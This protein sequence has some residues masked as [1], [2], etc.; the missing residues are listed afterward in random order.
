MKRYEEYKASGLDWLG[1]VPA[2][3]EIKKAKY[4]YKEMQSRSLDGSEDLLSVSQYTGVTRSTLVESERGYSLE[5]YRKVAS[6]D[7]VIN[8]MLAWMGALG[9]SNYVGIVS[10][11]YCVYR[12]HA[13][14]NPKFFGYLFQTPRYLAEFARCSHGIV[15]SR[16]RMYTEDFFN[17]T[18]LLPTRE[19]QNAIVAFLDRKLAEIDRFIANKERFIALLKEQKTAIINKAVTRGIDPDV[20]MKPSGI[21]WL[22]EIP[23]SWEE[24]RLKWY[25]A[26]V[27][28]GSRGW[29]DYYSDNGVIFLRIG[30]LSSE[31]IELKLDSIQR[32]DL[33]NKVEGIRTRVKQNDVLVSITASIGSIGLVASNLE[34]AYV[35]Q[36]IALLRLKDG[37]I[38]SKW[39]AYCLHSVV[40]KRQFNT[41][42]YGGTK[43]GLSLDDVRNI[44]VLSPPLKEQNRIVSFIEA[45]QL[46][47]DSTVKKAQR[48]IDLIKEYRTALIDAA[49]TGKIDVRAASKEE[50][51]YGDQRYL[52][53]GPGGVDRREFVAGGA[54]QQE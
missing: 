20:P 44:V 14:Y 32:V 4:L 16:W 28:S 48:E 43:D 41:L 2:H 33:P 39:L 36:H 17:V 12:A 23:A 25:V 51:A 1:K 10:P 30:N 13:E 18:C 22:G 19:E 46:K 49:V 15:E 7:L 11:A 52:G 45:S 9:V 37:W 34:E 5:G 47:I 27:T 6:G 31:S 3:W 38:D 53:N 50:Q 35:N 29:A 24:V 42:V 21:E 54:L 8:I 40:G 26:F